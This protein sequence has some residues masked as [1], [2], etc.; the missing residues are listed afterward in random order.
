VSATQNSRGTLN[1]LLTVF[2]KESGISLAGRVIG[3]VL[4]LATHAILT[5]LLTVP[6]YGIFV[7]AWTV[8]Q[9]IALF[10]QVGLDK[11]VIKYGTE[12][13]N[14]KDGSLSSVL[15]QSIAVHTLIALLFS[16]GMYASSHWLGVNVF[17]KEEL[18]SPLRLLAIMVPVLSGMHV[19]VAI[20]RIS[21]KMTYSVVCEKILQ[22]ASQFGLTILFISGLGMRVDGAIIAMGASYGLGFLL[23]VAMS[24]KLYAFTGRS[25]LINLPLAWDILRYSFPT[26]MAAVFAKTNSWVDRLMIGYFLLAGSVGVYHTASKISGLFMVLASMF[27]GIFA[28]LAADLIAKK[29]TENLNGIYRANT[30]WGLYVAMPL[31][32]IILFHANSIIH[33]VFGAPYIRGG[34][35]LVVLAAGQLVNIGT[36]SV[37]LVLMMGGQQNRWMITTMIMFAVNIVGNFL[38]IPIWGLWGAAIATSGSVATM[39][40]IGAL[41]ARKHVGVWPYDRRYF[42]GLLAALIACTVPLGLKLVPITNPVAELLISA[43]LI[44]LVFG[45]AV[46]MQGLDED[47]RWILTRVRRRLGGVRNIT[48]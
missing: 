24:L 3:T 13:L 2:A 4:Q 8:S 30:R 25:R 40:I 19:I 21:K 39:F 28:V 18:V 33:V 45:I 35:P 23:G 10:A 29:E 12:A 42:K 17:H 38:L 9:F 34:G 27:H 7:L 11:G 31:F 6:E 14:R 44:V 1:R 37:G 26:S 16:A 20:T 32:L 47:D 43:P 22:P 48:A 36:G 41:M 5:R 15:I 46:T